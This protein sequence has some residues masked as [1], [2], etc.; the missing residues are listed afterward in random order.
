[1][2][3]APWSSWSSNVT[4]SRFSLLL[5]LSLFRATA[6]NNKQKILGVS[7]ISERQE[8]GYCQTFLSSF[9]TGTKVKLEKDQSFVEELE[10]FNSDEFPKPG[11]GFMKRL[12]SRYHIGL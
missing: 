9:G 1:M 4:A 8:K 5:S 10:A 11:S 6:M 2:V 3:C 7:G 12:S